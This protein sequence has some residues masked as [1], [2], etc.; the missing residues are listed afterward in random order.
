MAVGEQPDPRPG[1]GTALRAAQAGGSAGAV[2]GGLLQ[3]ALRVGKRAHSETGIDSAGRSLVQV[4]LDRAAAVLGPLADT[5]SWSS[6]P[7]R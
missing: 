6:G 2:L 4:G 7:G 1:A 5:G 3:Q